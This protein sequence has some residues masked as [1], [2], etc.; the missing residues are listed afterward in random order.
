MLEAMARLATTRLSTTGGSPALLTALLTLLAPAC[1]DETDAGAAAAPAR[2]RIF[3]TIVTHNER[4]PHAE[5]DP[6]VT[7]QSGY[8][9]NRDLTLKLVDT[10]ISHGAALDLQ[11][12]YLYLDAV[13]SW[14]GAAQKAKTGGMNLIQYLAGLAPAQLVLDAHAHADDTV[15]YTDVSYM[16]ELMGAPRNGVL[17]G[18]LWYP[19]ENESWTQFREV[20]TGRRYPDA[21]WQVEILWGGATL[22]HR[23]PDSKASGVW[24]PK[25]AANFHVDDPAQT[26]VNV[27]AYAG[28][29]GGV[30]ELLDLL[31]AGS[32]EPNRMYTATVFVN[33]C[34][35]T[36]A[37]IDALATSIDEYAADVAAGDLVWATLPEVARIWRAEYDSM[38]SILQPEPTSGTAM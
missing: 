24:R 29:I 4:S 2:T 14:D 10:V 33:Q 8:L 13:K 25:D 11:S 5:C 37:S 6:V 15:N 26:L 35:I 20:E 17:G 34:S 7:V 19:T 16:H 12:D 28:A 1:G 21:T 38:P 30:G 31:H 27:G 9:A 32:L 36:G 22:Q 23:G 3:A 18:F